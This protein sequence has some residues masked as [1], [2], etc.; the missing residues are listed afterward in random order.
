MMLYDEALAVIHGKPKLEIG[1]WRIEKLN[2]IIGC[3][4]RKL[5]FVHIAGTNG[6]GSTANM[7]M[8]VLKESGYKVGLFTSPY[9]SR[10]NEYMQIDGVPISDQELADIVE[11]MESSARQMREPITEFEF[12]T[13]LA[14]EFFSRN[15]CDIVVLEVGMGGRL[16]CTNIISNTEAAVITSIG[17]DHMD[18]LGNTVEEIAAEKAGIIK[19]GADVILYQQGKSIQKVVEEKCEKEKVPLHIADFSEIIRT[20]STIEGQVFSYKEFKNIHLSLLGQHQLE[21]A[22]VALEVVSVLR[23]RGWKIKNDNIY[24]GLRKTTWPARFELLQKD[25]IVI[26]DGG[27]NPQCFEKIADSLQLYFPK[28]KV[29]FVM[30]VF[31]DKNYKNML[32]IIIPYAKRFYTITPDND[33]ALPAE[34]LAAVIAEHQVPVKKYEDPLT[35]VKK[36]IEEAEK[37]DVICVLGTFSIAGTIRSFYKK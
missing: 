8:N 24:D 31:K 20:T 37:D 35:G 36:A 7:I 32:E 25:P 17:L 22:A 26:L 13:E 34:E 1:L 21:N 18:V 10:I 16:D 19:P 14:F 33:R 30:G 11:F 5:K 2:E 29:I 28:K 4:D 9:L 12:V 15:N 3:P 23:N 27:H 6:K